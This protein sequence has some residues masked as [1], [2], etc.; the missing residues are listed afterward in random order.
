[1]D[2]RGLNK[3]TLLDFPGH[4]AATIFTGGC[5]FRCPFCHNGDLV[6]APQSIPAFSEDEIFSFLKKRKNILTGVCITGGEPTLQP[7]LIDFMK[8]IKELGYLIKLDTNGYKPDILTQVLKENLASYIAMDIKAG[9][10][11]YGYACGLASIDMSR[12]EESIS[13]L[14]NSQIPY[15]FR[16]TIVK[17][18]HTETD[19][20]EIAHMITGASAYFLQSYKESDGVIDK[21]YS[22]FSTEELSHFLTLVKSE[23]PVACLRGIDD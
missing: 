17:G 16:T 3:T 6:L 7:D 20:I 9:I 12:I 22:A 23:I 19:F 8:K 4:V 15:E 18:I 5:N 2:I 13:I 11:H 10:S 21:Q 1:M 14:M